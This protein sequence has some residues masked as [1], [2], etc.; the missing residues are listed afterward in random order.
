MKELNLILE[1]ERIKELMKVEVLNE[2]KI[3]RAIISGIIRS[4][5][6]PVTFVGVADDDLAK[7]LPKIAGS[8][9]DDV[10][11]DFLTK[12]DDITGDQLKILLKIDDDEI[13]N[14]LISAAGEDDLIKR[15][16][17]VL[18][19]A[20]KGGDPSD[21]SKAKSMLNKY[22]DDDVMDPIKNKVK[23]ELD[24]EDAAKSARQQGEITSRILSA[25]DEIDSANKVLDDFANDTKMTI[26]RSSQARKKLKLTLSRIKK[27]KEE[28]YQLL[29]RQMQRQ[30]DSIES[31]LKDLSPGMKEWF[32][33]MKGYYDKL[34]II[35]KGLF[36]IAVAASPIGA[37]A[38]KNKD[39]FWNV[40]SK[41]VCNI[42]AIVQ[43]PCDGNNA[44]TPIPVTPQTPT[45]GYANNEEGLKKYIS[46]TYTTDISQISVAPKLP[47]GT[48]EASKSGGNKIKF[49][50][51]N[52]TFSRL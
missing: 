52:G 4:T 48:W 11:L 36:W 8:Q 28:D 43:I 1:T 41:G 39:S 3:P 9:T 19:N 25:Q 35:G 14:A 6:K 20:E 12:A 33:G 38:A 50:Y 23:S 40:L 47:D 5:S 21:I 17:K 10:V 34:G 37:V 46:D 2:I 44:Q 51:N 42:R 24:A 22:M 30:V 45:T 49:S 15:L 31:Q 29:T 18:V 26:Y 13:R 7:V 32:N 16:M 27:L